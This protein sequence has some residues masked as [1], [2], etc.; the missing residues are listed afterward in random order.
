M[1]VAINAFAAVSSMNAGA[2]RQQRSPGARYASLVRSQTRPSFGVAA[3][4]DGSPL[5]SLSCSACFGRS[6]PTSRLRLT[7]A[8]HGVSPVWAHGALWNHD[9][10]VAV[11]RAGSR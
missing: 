4:S 8:Q 5:E 2:Q 7:A 9:A 1:G 3:G 10:G 6:W 11:N